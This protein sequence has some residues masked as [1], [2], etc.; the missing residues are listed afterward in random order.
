MACSSMETPE[1]ARPLD[2]QPLLDPATC[3]DRSGYAA[4]R[5]GTRNSCVYNSRDSF[6]LAKASARIASPSASERR[7]FT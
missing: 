1:V 6:S 4:R 5:R 3:G 2:L 7:S